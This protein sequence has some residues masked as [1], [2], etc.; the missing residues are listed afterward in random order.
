M[1]KRIKKA[2]GYPSHA[3]RRRFATVAYYRSGC[4]ILLVSRLLGHENVATTMRYIGLVNSDARNAVEAAVR[5]D[6]G[7]VASPVRITRAIGG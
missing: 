3:L 7:L 1:A 2:T 6:P 5:T 4:N